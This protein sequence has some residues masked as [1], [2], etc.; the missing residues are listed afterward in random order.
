MKEQVAVELEKKHSN[1][2]LERKQSK[3]NQN[4]IVIERKQSKMN[5]NEQKPSHLVTL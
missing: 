5:Q 2:G 4:D 1:I 3:L